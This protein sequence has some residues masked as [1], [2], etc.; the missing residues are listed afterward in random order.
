ME[1]QEGNTSEALSFFL[2]LSS[3]HIT[4]ATGKSPTVTIRKEGD[5]TSWNTPQGAVSEVGNGWYEV[6]PDADDADTLGT[7]KLHATAPACDPGDR[8]FRVV[9]AGDVATVLA[10]L[11]AFAG[12][13]VETVKGYLQAMS[14]KTASRPA[15]LTT[16]NPAVNSLEALVQYLP[17]Y[18]WTYVRRTLTASG[19]Q[20]AQA[21]RGRNITVLRGDTI[22]IT[23]SNLGVLTDRTDLWFTVKKS[24]D[25]TDANSILQATEDDGLLY[26]NKAAADDSSLVDIT[27]TNATTGGLTITISEEA[28]KQ[29]AEAAGLFYDIQVKIDDVV[30]TLSSGLF[31]VDADVTRAVG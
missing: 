7:L 2:T 28:S 8:E 10:R 22:T 4:G 23:L 25:D 24:K 29:L 13:G 3:D 6:A 14:S 18:V 17:Q 11:G 20:V 30:L 9:A 19:A 21:V 16:F 31:N 1:I 26:L 5:G 12:T 15:G 27:V